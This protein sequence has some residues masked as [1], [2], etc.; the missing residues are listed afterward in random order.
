MAAADQEGK[1]FPVAERPAEHRRV[2]HELE[3]VRAR[4]PGWDNH[5]VRPRAIEASVQ[6]CHTGHDAHTHFGRAFRRWDGRF[7]W[8]FNRYFGFAGAGWGANVYSG[9]FGGCE[10]PQLRGGRGRNS[11]LRP[12]GKESSVFKRLA[13]VGKFS[14]GFEHRAV[15]REV[16]ELQCGHGVPLARAFHA[17]V[18]CA[19]E[20]DDELLRTCRGASAY[21]AMDSDNARGI[22][23]RLDALPLFEDGHAD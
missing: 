22:D 5:F 20:V 8:Y 2:Q 18:W 6:P 4:D 16:V 13:R 17:N 23:L 7:R 14:A 3:F 19:F 9:H 21:W 12:P 10:Q 1:H 15:L 11:A